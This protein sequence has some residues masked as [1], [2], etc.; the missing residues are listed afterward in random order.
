MVIGTVLVV[1][2]ALVASGLGLWILWTKNYGLLIGERR[3]DEI[4]LSPERHFVGV[5]PEVINWPAQPLDDDYTIAAVH[6]SSRRMTK[7]ATAK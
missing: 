2:L 6:S 1:V 7:I 5:S 3:E 4:S